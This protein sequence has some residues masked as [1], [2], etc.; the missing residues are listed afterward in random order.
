MGTPRAWLG[1][2][3]FT[4]CA[5]FVASLSWH[6]IDVADFF[7]Q[8]TA[9][10]WIAAHGVPT[11]DVLTFGS[12]G[13]PWIEP[14]W[15]YCLGL[16]ELLRSA[17][18]ASVTAIQTLVVLATF[19]ITAWTA[20]AWKF[21]VASAAVLGLGAVAASDRFV[22]RPETLSYLFVALYLAVI[23]RW[24]TSGGKGLWVLPALQVLW[25]NLHPLAA[26]G[27]AMLVQLGL[28]EA[29]S[30]ERRE[31]L[32]TVLPVVVLVLL[33][34]VA[35]P[36]RLQ[37]ALIPFRLLSDLGGSYPKEVIEEL[38]SPFATYD[39]TSVAAFFALLALTAI[40]VWRSGWRADPFLCLLALTH[41]ALALS[42]VRNVPLF[43]LVAIP[44]ILTS[45]AP[46][47]ASPRPSD[48][49]GVALA[50][51]FVAGIWLQVIDVPSRWRS[52]KR[53]FGAGLA[54]NAYAGGCVDFLLRCEGPGLRVFNSLEQ[55]GTLEAAG[56]LPYFDPR[57]EVHSER[58]LR[59]SLAAERLPEAFRELMA[60]TGCQVAL[61]GLK[62]PFATD[63]A[64]MVGW[65]L[66]TFDA[67][68]AVYAAPEVA[69]RWPALDVAAR[70]RELSRSM[71]AWPE[72]SR[73][74]SRRQIERF[75]ENAAGAS[76]RP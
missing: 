64:P 57:L 55:G 8:V 53:V 20:R 10:R 4:L 33:A 24:R 49:G 74:V 12:V 21:P 6:R 72:A 16:A 59:R 43:V 11:R 36:Y 34:C 75:L 5:G 1:A 52:D 60:E 58:V 62:S 26:L 9:G 17:G 25:V 68:G 73:G 28:V 69:A 27:P 66:A 41:G 65:K 67:A 38:R 29:A 56:L 31:R 35:N 39:S 22:P 44:L 63:V 45:S 2:L 15:L 32:R 40:R 47:A 3:L 61:V 23:V 50:V 14:R 71:A 54:P 42:A 70:E 19:A 48:V 46:R 37:G 76:P 13:E 18:D 30:P 7:W 51:C